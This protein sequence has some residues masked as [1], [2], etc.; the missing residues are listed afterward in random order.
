MKARADEHRREVEF[1][2]GDMVFLKLR[3]YLQR[4]LA[5]RVNEKLSARFYGPYKVA[6]RVGKVAYRLHLPPEARIHPTFHVSQLKKAIGDSISPATIPPQL[7]SEGILDTVPEAVLAHR[8]NETTG[9][10]ELLIK[11]VGLS[12]ADC[13]WEWKSLIEKQ[14]L[15]L[16]LEDKVSLNGRG[17]VM[18]E[19]RRP[20]IVYQYR[21]R[22]PSQ[23]KGGN[24]RV[25]DSE[26]I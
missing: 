11:W 15:E 4:S 14:F 9:H 12:D 24:A 22:G 1:Q 17:N 6:A 8:V 19:A 3:P 2:E 13:T 21:R 18:Y 10:E 20:P 5:R 16:D 26:K 25:I 7:T 23:R